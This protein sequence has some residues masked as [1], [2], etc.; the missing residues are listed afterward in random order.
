MFEA[1]APQ[2]SKFRQGDSRT[3]SESAARAGSA[4]PSNPQSSRARPRPSPW[5]VAER[6]RRGPSDEIF[7]GDL[8]G[9]N[10]G[11]RWG[12]AWGAGRVRPCEVLHGE[13]IFFAA[14]R[15]GPP[16]RLN[17]R[18]SWPPGHR[19]GVREGSPGA[20]LVLPEATQCDQAEAQQDCRVGFGDRGRLPTRPHED[21]DG[22]S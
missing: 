6:V 14:R 9:W 15:N 21:V 3:E 20:R 12:Q 1:A 10:G 11:F 19:L 7:M 13:A 18:R 5:R 8:P 22:A 17:L 4:T 2:R 16:G